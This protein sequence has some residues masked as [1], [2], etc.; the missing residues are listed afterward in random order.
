MTVKCN[1]ETLTQHMGDSN[2]TNIRPINMKEQCN[3]FWTIDDATKGLMSM[4]QSCTLY[5]SGNVE[6]RYCIS[7]HSVKQLV[8]QS[9]YLNNLSIILTFQYITQRTL[10]THT[11]Y[12]TSSPASSAQ[13]LRYYMMIC[14]LPSLPMVMWGCPCGQ[15]LLVRAS[16]GSTSRQRLT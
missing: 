15:S 16:Q 9:V 4:Y 2:D 11:V 8:K 5:F 13:P 14:S 12:S 6:S 7:C 10:A 3:D 1:Q